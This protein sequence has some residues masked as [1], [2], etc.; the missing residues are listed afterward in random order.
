MTASQPAMPLMTK[1]ALLLIL[2]WHT[3]SWSQAKSTSDT[4]SNTVTY[5]IKK[6]ILGD[7]NND[8]SIDTAFVK[9]PKYTD[10]ENWGNCKDGGCEVE[11]SFSYTNSK[12]QLSNA[13]DAG[14]EAIGDINKDGIQELIVVPG[15]TIG[16]WGQYRFFT[17]KDNQWLEFGRAHRYICDE[18]PYVNC[19]V[20]RTSK[21]LVVME[22]VIKNGDQIKQKKKIKIP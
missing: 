7:M 12:I 19:I 17:V 9:M 11:I 4:L 20:K 15:W 14:I 8:T 6:V 2:L 16:C 13:V 18:E 5:D 10:E 3:L 22:D 1:L 21:T